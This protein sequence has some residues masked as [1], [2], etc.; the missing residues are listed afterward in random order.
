VRTV[1]QLGSRTATSDHRRLRTLDERS[2]RALSQR[3]GRRAGILERPRPSR[4]FRRPLPTAATHGVQAGRKRDPSGHLIETLPLGEWVGIITGGLN[5]WEEPGWSRRAGHG[6]GAATGG[7]K[8]RTQGEGTPLAGVPSA[9]QA[10]DGI[11]SPAWPRLPRTD[12]RS[13]SC[14]CRRS[15]RTSTRSCAFPPA[16]RPGTRPHPSTRPRVGRN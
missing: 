10:S 13:R 8:G 14:R 6:A 15:A 12:Y 16:R 2:K 4:V 5:S 3:Y 1:N 7:T 9:V 11:S